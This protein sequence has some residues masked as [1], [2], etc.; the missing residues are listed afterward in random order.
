MCDI[1]SELFCFCYAL[2]STTVCVCMKLIFVVV[3]C[4]CVCV[5][6]HHLQQHVKRVALKVH[7]SKKIKEKR[8]AAEKKKEK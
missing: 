2:V 3:V 4:V 1:N 7:K 6:V 5:F 8:E